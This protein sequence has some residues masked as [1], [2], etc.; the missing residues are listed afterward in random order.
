MMA[1]P[2]KSL[3]LHYPMIQFLINMYIYLL[4]FLNNVTI[5]ALAVLS[6]IVNNY[7]PKWR[8]LAVDVYRAAKRPGKY[9]PLATNTEV[10]SCFS[11]Y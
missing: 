5:K 2:M 3:E 8:R 4:V 6:K 9:P 10:N 7:S 1:K 11:L